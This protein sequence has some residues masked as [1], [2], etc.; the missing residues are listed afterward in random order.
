MLE[1]TS[2]IWLLLV[3]FVLHDM[4]ELIVVEEWLGKYN[5]VVIKKAPRWFK[6]MVEPSLTMSTAQFAV[7]VTCIFVVLASAVILTIFTWEERTFLPFFLVCLH[8][9]FLHS[10]THIGQSLLL[11]TYTPGVVTAVTLTLPYGLFAY[12]RLFTEGVITWSMVFST[13]PY[14]VLI[15]P[16]LYGAHRLGQFVSKPKD[17]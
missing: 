14:V 8:V 11:R 4:E 9:L 3:V 15:I 6:G 2:W 13:L 12:S 16:L 17:T 1:V 10:F 5:G 7:A